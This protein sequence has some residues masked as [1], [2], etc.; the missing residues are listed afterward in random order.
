MAD[1]HN[2]F[3]DFEKSI[4]ISQ[5]EKSE[6]L[7]LMDILLV[8]I[9][10]TLNTLNNLPSYEIKLLGSLK[11]DT[12]IKKIN[13]NND[14]DFGLFFSDKPS[15]SFSDLK[16]FVFNG[17]NNK[18]YDSVLLRDKCIRVSYKDKYD[19]DISIY[20]QSDKLEC[21]R[22]ARYSSWMPSDPDNLTN[23][24]DERA[25]TNIQIIRIIKYF[26]Y[27]ANN[28]RMKMPSG[29]ALSVLVINE[30]VLNERDDISFDLT[31]KAIF[32]KIKKGV[33]CKNPVKPFDNLV[34]NLQ[35]RQRKNFIKSLEILVNSSSEAIKKG[36][37]SKS[38]LIWNKIFGN[39]F[40]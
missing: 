14:V 26:K 3:L 4:S 33:Y 7:L 10:L 24:I 38:I 12:M 30:I 13:K 18:L 11:T 35:P 32:N 31:A 1:T 15:L 19:A 16:I 6:L 22:L 20:Y 34:G 39:N 40:Q 29:L 21:P 27:W 36:E 2:N 5:N 23:W 17:L 25:K 8:N 9:N 37:D 28:N